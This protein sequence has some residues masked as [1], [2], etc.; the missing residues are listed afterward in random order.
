MPRRCLVPRAR[1]RAIHRAQ[2]DKCRFWVGAVIHEK[3]AEC[4]EWHC[5]VGST[6]AGGSSGDVFAASCRWQHSSS[7]SVSTRD[8]RVARETFED[9]ATAAGGLG[10]TCRVSLIETLDRRSRRGFSSARRPHLFSA[11]PTRSRVGRFRARRGHQYTYSRARLP[12]CSRKLAHV[13]HMS[14]SNRDTPRTIRKS[15]TRTRIATEV[16]CL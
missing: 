5:Q 12:V 3:R 14:V 2:N 6:C 11:V 8:T 9:L 15:A 7:G 13:R 16:M 10:M 4:S 1:P